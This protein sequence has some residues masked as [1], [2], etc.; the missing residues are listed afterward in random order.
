MFIHQMLLEWFAARYVEQ[1]TSPGKEY[2]QGNAFHDQAGMS[3]ARICS[4]YL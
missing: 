4:S 3:V 1:G 2:V